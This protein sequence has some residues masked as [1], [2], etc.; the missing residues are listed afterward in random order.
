[1]NPVA[2]S[3]ASQPWFRRMGS[4]SPIV[5]FQVDGR[6]VQARAGDS[7][8]TAMLA[9]GLQRFTRNPKTGAWTAPSCQIGVC[10]GCLCHVDGRPGVQAC[11]TP[12]R[13]GMVVCTDA[14]MA[15]DGGVL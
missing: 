11:L 4:A 14:A 6:P 12:V 3:V 15:H 13:E 2:G 1:M 10:F 8:A 7:L 9:I 5:S